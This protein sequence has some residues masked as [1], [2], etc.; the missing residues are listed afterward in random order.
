VI[1][2]KFLGAGAV[3][4]YT[5]FRWPIRGEWVSAPVDRAD[6]WVHACRQGALPYWIHEEL[7][8]IELEAPLRE[9]RYQV[10]SP[11]ARLLGRVDAW[12]PPL[13]R[14]FAEACA[15]RARDVALSRLPP[16][17]HDAIAGTAD[18]GAIAAAAAAPGT[19]PGAY[20]ADIARYALQGLP[21]MTSYIEAVLASWLGGGLG[22][23]EAER[24]W[25][26]RWLGGQL[27]LD[28]PPLVG[29]T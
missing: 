24:A 29:A 23:F 2:F 6:V 3:A 12:R 8:R 18:L 27:G 28:A 1:A 19:L 10:A 9:T 13:A 14:E 7:W 15:W 25:Q 16:A 26:A 17:L 5:D 21:A 4:P 22:A 20:L 11:R